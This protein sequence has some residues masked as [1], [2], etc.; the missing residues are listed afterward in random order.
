M[1]ALL[2][3]VNPAAYICVSSKKRRSHP[4]LFMLGRGRRGGCGG[5]IIEGRQGMAKQ[6]P[7]PPQGKPATT[8]ESGLRRSPMLS[9]LNS[10][11]TPSLFVPGRLL[12]GAPSLIQTNRKIRKAQ[13]SYFIVSCRFKMSF[14]KGIAN[15]FYQFAVSAADRPVASGA[16]EATVS[17]QLT[18]YS[19]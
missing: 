13:I 19:A 9:S 7:V 3:E 18:R 6:G 5:R 2:G 1:D 16:V 15:L 8:V 17:S 11:F 12:G 14:S 10:S 4:M